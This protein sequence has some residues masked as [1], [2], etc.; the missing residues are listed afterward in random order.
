[1]AFFPGVPSSTLSK[2]PTPSGTRTQSGRDRKSGD[3]F[4]SHFDPVVHTIHWKSVKCELCCLRVWK[5]LG[6]VRCEPRLSMRRCQRDFSKGSRRGEFETHANLHT[7]SPALSSSRANFPPSVLRLVLTA[8]ACFTQ[9]APRMCEFVACASTET[10]DA[11]ARR[12]HHE[13]G[14]STTS[15]ILTISMK[16][17]ASG[18][19]HVAFK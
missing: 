1:M 14:P 5:P 9:A 10:P 13:T 6:F 16:T 4:P 2:P 19:R 3:P 11:N 8:E 12:V 18:V 17:P 7:H 15:P